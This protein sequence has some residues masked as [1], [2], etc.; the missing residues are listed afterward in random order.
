MKVS[1]LSPSVFIAKNPSN[2][3]YKPSLKL[4]VFNIL[5][6][7]TSHF[8]KGFVQVLPTILCY[9][10]CFIYLERTKELKKQRQIYYPWTVRLKSRNLHLSKEIIEL[11][12]P[13]QRI[14]PGLAAMEIPVII[15]C[16]FSSSI[17]NRTKHQHGH[18][19]V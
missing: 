2:L 8:S 10:W 17:T 6:Y 13:Y 1:A 7:T 12:V 4:F 16:L 19:A 9:K 5:F 18:P 15:D 14:V 11:S 3:I